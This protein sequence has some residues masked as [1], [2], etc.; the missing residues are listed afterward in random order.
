MEIS[1][2]ALMSIIAL[3][4]VVVISCIKDDLN[5]G[6]L[7]IAAAILVGG[8]FAGEKASDILKSFPLSLVMILIAVMFFFSMA[9]ANGTMS[10]ITDHSIRMCKG[11][12]A[13]IPV[14]IFC[15]GSFISMIGPGNIATCAMLAPVAMSIG[16]RIGISAF[17]MTLL[18]V[19]ACTGT[20]FSPFATS[21]II[22][23][24]LIAGFAP[25]VGIPESALS[26]IAWQV[27]FNCFLAQGVAN[28]GGFL[29]LGGAV[30]VAHHKSAGEFNIDEIAPKPEPFDTKQKITIALVAVM[31]VL[32]ILSGVPAF[33]AMLPKPLL[34]MFS[35]VGTIVF[36]LDAVM[37]LTGAGDS[38]KGVKG[39]PWNTIMMLSGMYILIDVMDRAGGLNALVQ[40]IASISGPVTVHFWTALIAGIISAYSSSTGVVMPMFLAMVPG[41]VDLTGTD[42][43]GFIST[44]DVASHLVDTSPLSTLGAICMASAPESEDKGKLFRWLL[45]WGLS[46]ALVAGVICTLLFGILG[47]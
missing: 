19:G 28:I 12:P 41:L 14:V 11:S 15:L 1:T 45:I 47:I 36:L 20:T 43:I 4:V 9:S 42:P 30:W 13:F 23:N 33:K 3:L 32:V 38:A 25:Q 6:F 39:M 16:K 44:V 5:V 31:I 24:G 22:S 37:L 34:L 2:A 17:L 46:M 8:L 29:L 10:K 26:G 35:N 7:G 40:L 21:G 18:V 27:F